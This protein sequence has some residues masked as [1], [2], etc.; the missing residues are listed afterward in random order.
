MEKIEKK[1]IVIDDQLDPKQK[2]T[3][4]L[5]HRPTCIEHFYLQIVL[6]N[7]FASSYIPSLIHNKRK[8]G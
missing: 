2:S 4:L 7:Y 8:R 3:S 5:F 6:L 1:E